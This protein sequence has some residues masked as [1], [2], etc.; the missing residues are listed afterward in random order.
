MMIQML[1]EQKRN[2]PNEIYI[3]LVSSVPSS[4]LNS[5]KGIKNHLNI[6]D[7]TVCETDHHIVFVENNLVESSSSIDLSFK[8]KTMDFMP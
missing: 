1:N 3:I 7:N 4:S 6:S 2:E 5:A 8:R